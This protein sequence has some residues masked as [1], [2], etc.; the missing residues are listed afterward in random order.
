MKMKKRILG[1]IICIAMTLSFIPVIANAMTAQEGAQW[2]IDRIGQSIDTDG[3][4][5]AQCKDFVNAYC[6]DN[7]GFTPPGNAIDLKDYNYPAGWQKIANTPDFVPQ[8]GDIAVWAYG[9]YSTYGHCGI[10]LSANVSNFVSVDQNWYNASDY[11]SPAARVTHNY[12][13]FWGVIRPPFTDP[14]PIKPVHQDNNY[15]VRN[16]FFTLKNASSGK[17]LN[18]YG[19]GD[20]NGNKITMWSYD[21]S[22]D[23][24][25]YISQKGNGKFKL[26]PYGSNRG[27]GRVVDVRR[28]ESAPQ[29]GHLIELWDN[30]DDEAQLVYLWP[31]GNNEYVI[32]L[33]SKDGYVFTPSSASAANQDGA[34]LILQRYNGSA[35]QKW[36]LCNNNGKETTANVAYGTGSYKIDTNGYSILLRSGPS[37]DS[38]QVGSVSDGT[39]LRVTQVNNNWGYTNYNGVNGWVCLDYSVYTVTLDSISI[40]QKPSKTTYYVGDKLNTDGLQIK[41][42]YSNNQSEQL[43]KDFSVSGDTSSPGAKKVTVKY[44]D[45][46]TTYDITVNS[47]SVES[48]S[49]YDNN[50]K[51]EYKINDTVNTDDIELCVKYANGTEDRISS[52]ITADY[53]FSTS[54]T[55]TVTLNYGG[56][57]TSYEV[58]VTG[59]NAGNTALLQVEKIDTSTSKAEVPVT[60]TAK[61]VYDGNITI[62]YDN[63]KLSISD[64]VLGG[65]L[66]SRKAYV[67]KDY[68]QNQIRVTFSGTEAI[69]TS[70]VALTLKFNVLSVNKDTS[71]IVIQGARLYDINGD[72]IECQTINGSVN[73][74]PT[75]NSVTVTNVNT[76]VA[77][78]IKTVN[79]TVS[80]DNVRCYLVKYDNGKLVSCDAAEPK[81]GTVTLSVPDGNAKL[82][83][84]NYKMKPLTEAKD[85]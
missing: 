13:G 59:N 45:K 67:N 35:Y 6:Q 72:A 12:N 32:E 41:A 1:V 53:D 37:T 80:D 42:N 48:I 16:G 84:W 51:K 82:L 77:N 26:H 20:Y 57:S 71:D 27:N 54:G 21:D 81:N 23:E 43:S 74:T 76:T 78:G 11:G 25:F 28:G 10:I 60:L 4:Y 36:K 7:W 31:V 66:S 73:Y 47:L 44:K 61:G 64:V 49:L 29:E 63:S 9:N 18:L 38:S 75:V 8:P 34:Q 52:G 56:K 15:H 46:T 19:G 3:Y 33:A 58:M 79:A 22:T 30:N 55:K 85:V 24:Q 5:G 50:I 40:A 70:D 69:N 62:Q 14:K 17:Y 2:A 65:V 39:V 68:A 83:V